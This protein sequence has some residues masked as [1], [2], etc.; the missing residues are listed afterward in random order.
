MTE[1]EERGSGTLLMFAAVVLIGALAAAGIAVAGVWVAI[2]RVQAAADL[3]AVSA[4]AAQ[5][6]GQDAC[7]AAGRLARANQVELRDCSIAG[8]LIDFAVT[9]TIAAPPGSL[10]VDF[11][12]RSHAGWVAQ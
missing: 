4:A 9:V 10:P 5:A 3:V 6:G 8:D 1:G 7:V 2:Q 12:T 11:T